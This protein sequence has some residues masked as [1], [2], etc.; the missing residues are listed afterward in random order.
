MIGKSI[1]SCFIMIIVLLCYLC[2]LLHSVSI[3]DINTINTLNAIILSRVSVH[4]DALKYLSNA[5]IIFIDDMGGAIKWSK[6]GWGNISKD[7]RTVFNGDSSLKLETSSDLWAI[8]EALRLFSP[9]KRKK[10]GF[11]FWWTVFSDNFGYIE[12]GIEYR[13]ANKNYR[14][15]GEVFIYEFHRPFYKAEN[16]SMVEFKPISGFP[17]RYDTSQKGGDIS[18]HFTMIIIDFEKDEYVTLIIDDV[19]V[20]MKGI[21]IYDRS[22]KEGMAQS[23][24][25]EVFVILSNGTHNR[26]ATAFID[27]VVVFSL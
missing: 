20:N 1:L 10:V 6:Y 18:W 22:T 14:K 21:K 11:C 26:T 12:F 27:D 25:M 23:N 8:I 3:T 17:Q 5:K 24:M 15:A 2:Y 16:G 7:D 19:E 4:P 13:N 9:P